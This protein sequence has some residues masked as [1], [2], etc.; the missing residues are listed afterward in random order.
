M[1]INIGNNNSLKK[2]VISE[3]SDFRVNNNEKFSTKHPI[4]IS[5]GCSFIVGFILLFGFWDKI[6]KWIEGWF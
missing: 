6:I 5:I 1:S 3:K 4:I 2:T